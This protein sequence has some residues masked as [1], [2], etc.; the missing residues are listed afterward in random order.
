MPLTAVHWSVVGP[1]GATPQR[2]TIAGSPQAANAGDFGSVS[3]RPCFSKVLG[4][5]PVRAAQAGSF[6]A[7]GTATF[8]A[9]EQPATS[10]IETSVT[11]VSETDPAPVRRGEWLR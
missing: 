4:R 11:S 8:T 5:A 3:R 2:R 7:D 1:G 10:S 6:P 9:S